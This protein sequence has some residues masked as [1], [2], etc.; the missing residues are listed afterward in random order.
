M[1]N[2]LFLDTLNGKKTNR[3][4]VWI[5]RQAGRYLEGYRKLREKK[6]NFFEFVE[7]KSSQH[8]LL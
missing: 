7:I 5:M 4:P 6:K 8:K 3:A 1:S 2:N